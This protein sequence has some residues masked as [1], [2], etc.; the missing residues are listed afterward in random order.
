MILFVLAS[1]DRFHHNAF[2]ASRA[3]HVAESL[4]ASLVYPLL[5]S[6]FEHQVFAAECCIF[7]FYMYGISGC[8]CHYVQELPGLLITLA[9]LAVSYR[10]WKCVI[11]LQDSFSNP[12]T[13]HET[14]ASVVERLITLAG[15]LGLPDS[16]GSGFSNSNT[17]L[18]T[19]ISFKVCS[20]ACCSDCSFIS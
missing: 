9:R 14:A 5:E 20:T 12:S 18:A 13:F 3:L 7:Y 17:D 15:R 16:F 1:L 11:F 4:N 10:Y 2:F 19:R 6:I 8:H